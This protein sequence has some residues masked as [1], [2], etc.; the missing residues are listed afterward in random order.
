MGRLVIVSNR[1]P[2][3]GRVPDAGGLAVGLNE[4]L[5]GNDVLWFGWSGETG[6]VNLID[7][8]VSTNGAVTY[9][10]LSLT[11]EEYNR[12]YVGFANGSL[13]PLFHF[14]IG[15][16]EFR[17]EYLE[18]YLAVNRKFATALAPMLRP[19]DTIW[20][21]DYHFMTFADELRRQG[22]RNRIGFFLHTPFVPASVFAALPRGEHLLEAMCAY[23]VVGFQTEQDRLGFLDCLHQLL[24]VEVVDGRRIFRDG[25]T[26]GTLTNPIG[27]DPERFAQ[28]ARRTARSQEA[29][30]LRES[31][32]GRALILGVERL[33]YSKGLTHRFEG[34]R[35][36]LSRFPDHRLQV[37][38]LQIA[39]RSRQD[40]NQYRAL[41]RELDQL[42]GNINGRFAEFDWVP[43]RYMTRS[44]S[45]TTLAGFH[46]IARVGLVTPLRD[47]M[48]LVAKEYVAAQDP[49]DPGVLVLSRFAG[50]AR[51]LDAALL[52]N[53][54]DP[55][56][57]AESLHLALSMPADERIARHAALLERVRAVTA[58]TW[59]R[60]M[61]DA[62]QDIPNIPERQPLDIVP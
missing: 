61:L 8:D 19:D 2:A 17:R 27:I 31:L 39:A 14:R 21:H 15:L 9:A 32:V 25:R 33:D 38:Y 52:V 51:E 7:P 29:R 13:W 30:R 11:T 37:S 45:R 53:P 60:R 54:F 1:V 24:G 10:T 36:L 34:F 40:V 28:D 57:I 26:I 22:V 42:A 6:G 46:R 47:G 56:E 4:A 44:M 62:L 58:L 3:S 48:N 12:F 49:A 59:C 43:L 20:V 16:M 5:R 23:D 41:R 50:A 18:G 35:R 55:D